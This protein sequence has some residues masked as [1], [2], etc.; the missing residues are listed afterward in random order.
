LD[1]FLT[2]G[3]S[4]KDKEELVASFSNFGQTRVDVFAPGFEIYNSVPQSDYK[5]LQGTSMAAP[6]VS[7]VA[8]MLKSYFPT[9]SMKEIKYVM[10]STSTKYNVQEFATKS[11][12]GGVVNVYNAVKACQK[13]ESSKK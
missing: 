4:T 8:A 6:M 10:L 1:H 7:G 5:N 9:L 2:I 11:V 3:A 12:T 13:L